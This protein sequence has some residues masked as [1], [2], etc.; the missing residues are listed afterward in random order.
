[1]R[2]VDIRILE[3]LGYSLWFSTYPSHRGDKEIVYLKRIVKGGKTYP[4]PPLFHNGEG[5][6]WLAKHLVEESA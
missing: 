1:M 5:L 3:A 4:P 6:W 2:E